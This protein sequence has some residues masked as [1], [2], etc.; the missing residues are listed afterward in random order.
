MQNRLYRLLTWIVL[1]L[2]LAGSGVAGYWIKSDIDTRAYQHFFSY[3]EEIQL[4]IAAR[5]E[6]HEQVLLG[7]AALFEA[8]P[9]VERQ[10]WHTYV[11][12]LRLDN[13]FNGIQG[14]GFALW[15]PVEQLA[16]HEATIRAEGFPDYKV[17]PEGEREAYSSI[18][19][20][21]P[22]TD[23]NLRAFGYDM[24]SEPVRR[25]AMEQ[26]RDK[27]IVTLSGR[28]T[29]VQESNKD[30]QAG[31]LMYVPVYKK[32]QPIDTVEQRR[33][34]LF[35][36]VYSPFRM[37]D[38]LNN[39][40]LQDN[41]FQAHLRIYDGQ[42]TQAEH[43]FYDNNPNHSDT[44]TPHQHQLLVELTNNFNGTIWTLQF[45]KII[46][47]NSLDYEGVW[48]TLST[49]TL[50][51]FLLF[52]L[53]NS[54]LN[55]RVNA[56]K[57]ATKLTRELKE[58]E[59][60]FRVLADNAPVL[61]WIAGV[62][63]QCYQLNK[64]WLN[65]TGRTLEQEQGNGWAEGVHADDLQ[66]CLDT[67]ISSFDAHLP[68]TMEYRLRR[69]DGEYR[70]LLDTG[71]PRFADDGSFLGYIGSCI[72][73][74]DNK[75]AQIIIEKTSSLLQETLESSNEAILVVDFNNMWVVH[76]QNFIEMWHIPNEIIISNDDN[77]ALSF[78]LKQIEDAEGFLNKVFDL[79]NSP[80]ASSSDIINLKNGKIIERY[81]IPQRI[82]GKVVGRV[83]RF[84]DITARARA[85][86]ALQRE[87]EKNLALL[88]NASDGIHILD[89]DGNLI[90]FSDSFCAMLGYSRE[91]MIGMNVSQWD[92][93]FSPDE[94]IKVVRQQLEKPVHTLFETQHRC[95]DGRI[96]DV[97]VSGF[98]LTLDGKPVL[99]NSSRDITER[100]KAEIAI[101]EA[102]TLLR[103]II[104]TAPM[105]VF[106]KDCNLRYLG[107]N[108]AFAKDAGMN[109]PNDL[110]G[111]DDYQLGWQDQ[112]ELYRADDRAVLESGIAKLSYDEPQTTP[113]GQTMWLRTS[114]VILRNQANEP[115][116]LLGIY[117]DITDY[118]RV[119]KELLDSQEL[120]QTA[121]RIAMLAH[122][123]ID[124]RD[125]TAITWINDTLFNE[126]FG[127]GENYKRN[128]ANLSQIIH[129]D[130]LSLVEDNIYQALSCSPQNPN[131][132]M[133]H[134]IIRPNDGEERWIAKW[135]CVFFDE[136]NNPIRQV[137]MIQDIT[138]RKHL[139]E[140]IKA[141]EAFTI[142]IINSLTAHIAVLDE[143]GVIVMVNQAWRQFAQQNDLPN[144][145]CNSL[146]SNYL[147]ICAKSIDH[148]SPETA[149]ILHGIMTVLAGTA[150]FYHIEYTCDSLEEKRWFYMKV[151]PLQGVKRG[152]VISHENI[153]ERKQAELA[154]KI[155]EQ[156]FR[157]II[158]ISPVPMLLYDSQQNIIFLNTTFINT[159]DYELSDIPTVTDWWIKTCPNAH[160]RQLMIDAWQAELEKTEQENQSFIPLEVIVEC[161][162]GTQKTILFNE[163]S[164]ID[165][166]Y[167]VVLYDITRL[168]Q[169]EQYLLRNQQQLQN[170]ITG[171]N[172]G[173][174]EWNVQTGEV[175]FNER[176]ANIIG[177]KLAELQ[178][179]SIQT[180]R[181][182][183]H[184]D[185]LKCAEELLNK[186]FAG[187]LDCYQSEF[188]M[189]HKQGHWVWVVSRGRVVSSTEDGKPLLMAGTHI[190]ISNAKKVEAE[191]RIAATVFESQE[192]MLI[193]DAD[194][195]ILNVNKAFTQV[196]G[197]DADEAIGQTPRLLHSGRH[198]K[199]F[200]TAMW[201]SINDTGEWHGEIWNRRKNGDIYPEQLTI[202]A[203]K[204]NGQNLVTHYVAT[205]VDITER[206]AMED[207]IHR[208]AFY[209]PLTQLP[210][211]RLLQERIKHGIELNHRT[212]NQM[213][214]LMMDLDKFKAVNDTQG[215][216]AGDE[217]LQQVAE[218]VKASLREV[219]MVARL[220]GDEF[221]ILLEN[222]SHYE[223]VAHVAQ[224]IIDTLTQPFTLNQHHE[225]SIGASIGI[226]I[227]PQ[228]GNTIEILMD[229]ADTALYHAKDSGRGCFTYFSEAL[230]KKAHE[231]I[232]LESRLHSAIEQQELRLYFQPQ[233]EI[234]SGLI[235]G[236]ET[237]VYWNDSGK[238][239]R[240]ILKDFITLAEETGVAVAIG[241]WALRETCKLGRQWLDEGLP[242]V[243]L[244][245]NISSY[246]FRC[247][248]IK[249]LVS[250]ILD[251]T[252]LP[253]D[254]LGL[255][256]TETGL[257]VNQQHALSIL[258]SLNTR[259]IQLAI[260]DFGTGYSSLSRLKSFPIDI[261]KI[262]KT[263]INNIPFSQ[264]D[265]MITTTIIDIAHHLDFKVLAE[266]VETPKQLTFLRQQG[267]DYYQG[268]LYSKALSAHDFGLLLRKS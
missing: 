74:T 238:G 8:S 10:E 47:T 259:S 96:L 223:H 93:Y 146:G 87:S 177:Y 95:K 209:D 254:Y 214:V 4:K 101:A 14:L 233:I 54:Y 116:G 162:D 200:Y 257:M 212:G 58:S 186:H 201:Q 99:F 191:L 43:L 203:V 190:D 143:Q 82:N 128:F 20:L 158:E 235:V 240:V 107:C 62:D 85:E 5:L 83:W 30:V 181:N 176:W 110:I 196:T 229:N 88:H 68:F 265:M 206:K 42:N 164:I 11:D 51:S 21:E 149:G 22:F 19:F 173:T 52:L 268:D 69:Y 84:L 167:L 39:I 120:L 247:G 221:V 141:N 71:V 255:E 263:F 165:Y 123:I 258:N 23:R 121:Q 33:A 256:I 244:A 79:Y 252:G 73:I 166:G 185:D 97:E 243:T 237:L 126:I 53:S 152:V 70:W 157:S 55:M 28:V 139:E 222:V 91:E 105:R 150:E 119:E 207:Y 248:D 228:H 135:G 180:W 18:I 179:V 239:D 100:K 111:K 161:K 92:V 148:D 13:H 220:G 98:P 210:N 224:S 38:L 151:L 144:A 249:N 264:D 250:Q 168:K 48:I 89:I 171:T 213:A 6:A 231:R 44:K 106:W 227:C 66:H 134:R 208:L 266:G 199:E 77:A 124:L 183:C 160:Y 251:E 178:P 117:E 60:R 63:K 242:M 103:S 114:K 197:Y 218:R 49:G 174:W 65:F 145:Y 59:S 75:E 46:V 159:F 112:A 234:N 17:H 195:I 182:L 37:T 16:R 169:I 80:E 232:A 2:G 202:T 125:P 153:T 1:L 72:D 35:G 50:I 130:D 57:I 155:S 34:A 24:Y 108:L 193:T 26:A 163:K 78:I 86:Q 9:A 36:W 132:F 217:L 172:A 64:V 136:Q 118:K 81:S 90:E 216:A 131:D 138:K 12:R 45:E 170:I 27:N 226:S 113:S 31:S 127:L 29:L 267:C 32:G 189:K 219:D 133:E 260:D 230:N 211:R 104:D 175:V 142:D 245:V 137:G 215:H 225:V 187:E 192:G 76:N 56:V 41:H 156:K 188:Q 15:I 129:P 194:E 261:L 154:L 262:D 25:A 3:C 94:C 253:P 7:G 67:Y 115:I 184:P 241:E 204:A 236:A 102:H 140:V 205:L 122:Y 61:I 109:C 246:L 147:E 198:D 40:V